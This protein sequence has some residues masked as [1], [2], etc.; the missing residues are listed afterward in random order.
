MKKIVAS[1][2]LV[3][4]G[5]SGIQTACA[6]SLVSA[7]ASKPWS[8]SATLRGFYDD[9]SSTIPNNVTLPPGEHRDTFGFEVS[10][11][12]A[13]AWSV[14][15]TTLT[16]GAL[17][18]FRHYDRIPL[19]ATGHNDN[20][21]TFNAGLTHAFN[22]Q[23]SA[24]VSDS[25]VIGQEP[26]LLRAGNTFATFQRVSGNNIR[27]YGMIG[28]DAQLTPEIGVSVGYDNAFYDYKDR[29]FG[30]DGLAVAPSTAGALNR[31]ENRAHVEL[32]YQVMP[33]TK[34]LVGYQFT[35]IDYNAGE[36]IGGYV[37]PFTGA[38]INPVFSRDRNSREHTGYVGAEHSFSQQLK[39]SIRVGASY[40]EYPN[41]N[42]VSSTWTPYVNA[43][44]R[45]HYTQL[46]YVEGGFSYDRNATDVVG[47]GL[48]GTTTLDAESAVVYLSVNHAI[49]PQL[50]ASLIGQFQNSS[51]HGGTYNN[52]DEQ[53]YLLG[54]NLSYRFNQYFSAEVGYN[55]D[56]LESSSALNRTFDR[57]R[58]YIGVTA[59]Y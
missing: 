24:R 51:Y 18:S 54:L 41:D 15:Q 45:F 59:T 56:R 27:N 21:F 10:P 48:P 40:T 4:I 12:A 5:A 31:I 46:S 3:A 17:Y 58:V 50:M 32:N 1:V 39:G 26:D 20:T 13:L 6:Q 53:Y 19:N 30:F 29:G 8:V 9:N 35:D 37:D 55:Y 16:L 52:N 44:L 49:T 14:D 47:A 23:I 36:L 22:E 25:F 33:E 57:N 28:L 2:G 43:M 7:D 34:A 38:I 42:T 11:A